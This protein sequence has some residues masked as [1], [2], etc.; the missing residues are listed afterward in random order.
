MVDISDKIAILQ[1]AMHK[2]EAETA[3]L[4]L[5][6]DEKLAAEKHA[7]KVSAAATAAAK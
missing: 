5:K 2:A 7:A 6:A 4:K 1:A 3:A